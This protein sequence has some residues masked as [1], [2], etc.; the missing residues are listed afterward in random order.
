MSRTFTSPHHQA[1]IRFLLK[2]R[3]QAGMTQR[4]LA[5]RLKRHQS[6][7]ATYELGQKRID[8][9][10][11]FELGEALG[12]DPVTAVKHLKALK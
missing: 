6:F 8:V 1:L 2:K 5:K 12:F 11:L 7:V 9:V 10:E 4:D 3:E